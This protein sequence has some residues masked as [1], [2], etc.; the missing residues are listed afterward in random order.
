MMRASRVR[1]AVVAGPAPRRRGH[2]CP[3]RR[4]PVWRAV[5]AAPAPTKPKGGK[6]GLPG[7]GPGRMRS[8]LPGLT[9]AAGTAAPLIA[10]TTDNTDIMPVPN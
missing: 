8:V 4:P 6:R 5:A 3:H 10:L 9:E 1:C 7:R 2:R